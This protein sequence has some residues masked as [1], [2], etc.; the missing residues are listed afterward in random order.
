LE[1]VQCFSLIANCK[2]VIVSRG[3]SRLGQKDELE[4][5]NAVRVFSIGWVIL[6]H[7]YINYTFFVP[8][9]NY[10]ELSRIFTG[11]E[12]IVIYGGFYAVDTFFWL[13]GLLMTYLFLVEFDKPRSLT[14]LRIVLVYV[15]RIL[16]IT[17]VYMFCLLFMW[18]MTPYLGNGPLWFNVTEAFYEDCHKYW[19][20]NLL[21]LNNFLPNYKTESCLGSSWYLADD[22]QFFFISPIILVVYLKINKLAAWGIIGGLNLLNI[23]TSAAI[24]HHFD[25]N[26]VI[27][28]TGN[29]YFDYYYVKPYCRV[30]PYALGIGC[31]IILHNYRKMK[32][33]INV[34]DS[35]SLFISRSFKNFYVRSFVF[36]SQFRIKRSCLT[37]HAN[38]CTI[39]YLQT[40]RRRLEIPTLV[41]TCELHFYCLG[42]IR[43]WISY[44]NDFT[45]LLT[46]TFQSNH[47]DDV[48]LCLELYCEI[49]FCHV[50][51]SL[52]NHRN[53]YKK[54]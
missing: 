26:P 18:S 30:A 28:T 1:L 27:F 5:L 51:D 2:R 34:T 4:L 7:T 29:N 38:I 6:G 11:K 16:R 13:S 17:P 25:L 40:P 9:V 3:E 10:T 35:I 42:K 52:W 15:H 39:R 47:L 43:L 45:T 23:A 22:M 49:H 54:Y 12:Y 50:F 33:S 53:Y 32:K 20:A 41:K 24:A 36:A 48:S 46:R 31:G 8:C 14:V 44:F 21:Y 19:Y 37:K